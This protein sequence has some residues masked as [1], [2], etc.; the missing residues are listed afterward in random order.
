MVGLLAKK[1]IKDYDNYSSGEV[2]QQYGVLSGAVGIGLNILLFIVKLTAGFLSGSVAITADAIN[3]LGDAGSSILM[4][5]GFKLAGRKPDPEHPFGHGRVEYVTGLVVSILIVIMGFELF[6]SSIDK[7]IHP[8]ELTVSAIVVAIL[9]VSV[10][11]KFYMYYYN[12]VLA[13]KLGSQTLNATSKDSVSDAVSTTVVLAA[14]LFTYFTGIMIDGWCGLL[15]ACFILYTGINSVKDTLDPLLGTRPDPEYVKTIE[16]FVK[17]FDGILG[18]HD[19]VVH[20][21]GPGRVMIS[22]HAEVSA[23]CDIVDIHDTI[24]VIEHKLNQTL[25]CYSVIHMDP[26]VVNDEVTNRMKRFTEL[27]VK[28]IDERFTMHDFRMV[29]GATHTNLIFDVVA[30]YDCDLS[31]EE[32]KKIINDIL[33]TLPERLIAVVTIDRPMV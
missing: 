24:D 9:I 29:K 26:I 7:I 5:V 13:K 2:R 19:M 6:T 15:V 31:P 4:M 32:I 20:D 27:V 22:L 14:M 10:G 3:N 30:P 1:F 12:K 28:S 18:V 25:G 17:S 21:Y 8:Q 16:N 11:V 33:S 23:E